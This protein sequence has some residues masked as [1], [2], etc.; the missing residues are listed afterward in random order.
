M[1]CIKLCRNTCII[2]ERWSRT[3]LVCRRLFSKEAR[4]PSS[5]RVAIRRPGFKFALICCSVAQSSNP[6]SLCKQPSG[7]LLSVGC[8]LFILLVSELFECRSACKNKVFHYFVPR[9]EAVEGKGKRLHASSTFPKQ[10]T[11]SNRKRAFIP[12]SFTM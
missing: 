8:V 12:S 5:R 10:D 9:R 3:K 1:L 4:W 11:L 6:Q 2:T 7:C